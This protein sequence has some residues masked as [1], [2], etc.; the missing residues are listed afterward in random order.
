MSGRLL[1]LSL[2]ETGL[3]EGACALMEHRSRNE[4]EG[5]REEREGASSIIEQECTSSEMDGQ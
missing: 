3:D 5:E 2:S 1:W 4:G